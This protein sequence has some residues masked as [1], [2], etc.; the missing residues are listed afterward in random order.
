MGLVNVSDLKEGMVVLNPVSNK[1]GNVL[2]KKGDTLTEKNMVLLKSWGITEVDIESSDRHQAEGIANDALSPEIIESI[3]KEVE[4]MFP[5]F[6]DNPL[7]DKLFVIIKKA[8]MKSAVEHNPGSNDET[9][10]N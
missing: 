9:G 7:M 4:G 2:L 8:K 10:S 5:E 3:D 6:D 1:H